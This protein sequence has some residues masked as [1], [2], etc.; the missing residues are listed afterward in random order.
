M[1]LSEKIKTKIEERDWSFTEIANIKNTTELLATEILSDMTALE[2]LGILQDVTITE[3]WVGGSFNTMFSQ[4]AH[5]EIKG[6]IAQVISLM[7][8][9]ATV[10]FGGNKND[11]S[12]GSMGGK[13]H[14]ERTTDEKEDS[15]E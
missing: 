3:E 12:E 7:L 13:P 5:R 10:N 6:E 15:E 9:S 8:N 11:I 14:K 4:I 1:S 2:R